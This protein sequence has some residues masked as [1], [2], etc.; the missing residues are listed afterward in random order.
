MWWI[1]QKGETGR[2]GEPHV[3]KTTNGFFGPKGQVRPPWCKGH[4]TMNQH[5][6]W[7]WV[8]SYDFHLE[9]KVIHL[10]EASDHYWL[11]SPEKCF[12]KLRHS[13]PKSKTQES[14]EENLFF[15]L[16]MNNNGNW[17]LNLATYREQQIFYINNVSLGSC[18]KKK[19]ALIYWKNGWGIL[20][21][22]SLN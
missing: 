6:T 7:L 16:L 15:F 4:C 13:V 5:K 22:R 1:D 10:H 9:P 21:T 14:A 17:S 20:F 18:F 3:I 19:K 2:K 11:L 8:V 12:S